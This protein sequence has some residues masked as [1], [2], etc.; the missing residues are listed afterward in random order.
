MSTIAIPERR[1]RG[2]GIV[3][4]SMALVMAVLIAA[5]ALTQRQPPPPTVAEFAPQA[6]EQ[7][8]KA[9]NEQ[10]SRFG[11]GAGG[12]GD[13]SGAQAAKTATLS[14][15][16]TTEKPIDKPRVS[17]CI[18]EPA[19]QIEDPQSPPC[20]PYWDGDNGGAT[21]KGVSGSDINIV[22]PTY[23]SVVTPLLQA[24]FNTRF[25]FYGRKLNL[26]N[27]AANDPQ[28]DKQ[29]AW[30]VTA[31]TQYHA[32]ASA[33]YPGNGTAYYQELAN[34]QI[35]A[36][37]QRPFTTAKD[38]AA[39]HPYLWEY[40]MAAD[41]ELANMA[42]WIC[43]RFGNN[44]VASHAGD[45]TLRTKPRVL[46]V[47]FDATFDVD[48]TVKEGP[49]LDGLKRCNMTPAVTVTSWD[50]SPAT[51]TQ[52][53]QDMK[54]K[55][56]TSVVCACIYSDITILGK[57][58]STQGF[59]PEWM[60]STFY[61]NDTE[62]LT[63]VYLPSEQ[64]NGLIGITF[65]PRAQAPANTP[66]V[67]ALKEMDPTWGSDP[68]KLTAQAVYNLLIQYQS[69]LLLAS[70]IQLAGPHLTPESF[71]RGLQQATFPNA[72]DP[73]IKPGRVGFGGGSHSMT[74]DGA[75]FYWSDAGRGPYS[76]SGGGTMCF[77]D[78]GARHA[79]GTWPKG[80]FSTAGPCDSG[81]L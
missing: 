13:G 69:L 53:V 44:Q 4:A 56:V 73:P 76:D 12:A 47:L 70:G 17:R 74:L 50:R 29:R 18:G 32:F 55:G 79:L 41:L 20:V 75:E 16:T 45:P 14:T 39:A 25:Q 34:R 35:V 65:R 15:T 26:I 22:M 40:T 54:D 72:D 30:A 8:K 51:G 61:L 21:W 78:G 42:D 67:W 31:D 11:S 10:S 24:F 62:L 77:I 7:I 81:A 37:A 2:P 3:H 71:A 38:L 28:S 23:D 60:V 33:D 52:I 80:D 59:L 49:L 5:V 68:S 48:S 1:P 9:P 19:R 63:K 58:A 66:V 36:A 46:G 57:Q 6:V 27:M 43:S 64:R